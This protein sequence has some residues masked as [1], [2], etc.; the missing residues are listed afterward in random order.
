MVRGVLFALVMA[1]LLATMAS[2]VL[3]ER[4]PV[5]TNATFYHIP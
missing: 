3:A 1:V 5:W 4:G 2:T